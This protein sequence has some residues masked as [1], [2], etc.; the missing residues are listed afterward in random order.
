MLL[1]NVL[2]KH[3]TS[4][5]ISQEHIYSNAYIYHKNLK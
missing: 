2:K 4:I 5:E 3:P 1:N